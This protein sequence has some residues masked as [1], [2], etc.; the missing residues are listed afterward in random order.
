MSRSPISK[1]FLIIGA[2]VILFVVWEQSRESHGNGGYGV[3]FG[4]HIS[5]HAKEFHL[6]WIGSRP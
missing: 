4:P 3:R 5:G 2:L 6:C 1:P